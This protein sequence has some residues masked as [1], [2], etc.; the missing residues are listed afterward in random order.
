MIISWFFLFN[1]KR[2]TYLCLNLKIIFM[3]IILFIIGFLFS[4]YCVQAQNIEVSGMQS[5]TWDSDTVLVV[6]NTIVPAGEQLTIE[7]GTNVIFRDCFTLLVE[8]SL[9]AIGTVED[10][11]LFTIKDTL[12]FSLLTSPKGGWGGIE[13]KAQNESDSTLFQYCFMSYGK[14]SGDSINCNGGAICINSSNKVSLKNCHF[15]NN[16][17]YISGGAVFVHK[18]NILVKDCLF[19]ENRAGGGFEYYGYGGGLCFLHCNPIVYGTEFYRNFSVGLGGGMSL[20]DCDAEVTNCIF[21]F[22][23]SVIGGGMGLLR[24]YNLTKSYSNI[25]AYGNYAMHFGGGVSC[26]EAS[27]TFNNFTI[28]D[29]YCIMG[30]GL[31][32]NYGSVPIITNCIIHGNHTHHTSGDF[33]GGQVWIWDVDSRPEFRNC[34]IEGDTTL[35]GGHKPFKGIYDNNIDADPLFVLS[36]DVVDLTND[37]IFVV[38]FECDYHLTD[39]SPCVDAGSSDLEGLHVPETDLQMIERIKNG[40][41]DLGA[42]EFSGVAINEIFGS[43]MNFDLKILPNPLTINS[44]CAFN[45]QQSDFV[46]INIYNMKGQSVWN[47]ELGKL[48]EGNHSISLSEFTKTVPA[49]NQFYLL[50]VKITNGKE[51]RKL[52]Y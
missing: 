15:S 41:I 22:N 35:F 36:P 50:E 17:S 11:I 23:S 12:G 37:S 25:L 20:D 10:S 42:Y 40:R 3:K 46:S 27:P 39:E 19:T 2:L 14:A 28:T 13:I 5:G 38:G 9:K 24:S 33:F 8:G 31:F 7:P 21:G 51:C 1:T 18:S 43:N 26:A 47:C 48:A 16:Y 45:M 4:A 52:V 49:S 29:N 34:N 30:G 32:I 44:Q 6:G